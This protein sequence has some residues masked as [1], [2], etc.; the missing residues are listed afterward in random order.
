MHASA[1]QAIALD[2]HQLLVDIDPA[3]IA[4][5]PNTADRLSSLLDRVEDLLEQTWPDGHLRSLQRQLGSIAEL[6]DKAP[7][8]WERLDWE[9]FRKECQP[10]YE[11]LARTL[12]QFE[13][14]VPSLRPTNYARNVYHVINGVVIIAMVEWVLTPTTMIGLAATITAAAWTMETSR[15]FHPGINRTLMRVFSSVAHPHEAFRVN[16]ATW[17]A[18]ALLVVACLYDKPECI[19]AVAVLGVGDPAAAIIG[20]RFGTIPLLNGRS[21]Q[22]TLAFVVS[23]SVAAAAVLSV[24]H[25]EV[26]VGSMAL[27][28]AIFGALAELVSRRLDDNLTIPLAA[29]TG[30]WMFL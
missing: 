7:S 18:S 16:S 13:I 4:D 11:Q 15:R 21:L 6:V 14:H 25:P 20:R 3:R 8:Q 10:A 9:E 2:L 5:A 28:A 17:F 1:S 12:K 29:A 19:A 30:A 24:F 23:A 22:G 26:N 27:G